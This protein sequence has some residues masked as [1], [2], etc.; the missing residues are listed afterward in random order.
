TW[1]AKGKHAK[2]ADL[3]VK[4]LMFD[5]TR[6]YGAARPA[7]LSLP[8]YPFAKESYWLPATGKPILVQTQTAAAAVLHPLVQRNISDFTQQ[9]FSAVFTGEEFFLKDHIVHGQRILPGVAYLEMAR[10]AILHALDEPGDGALAVRLENVAWLQPLVVGEEPVELYIALTLEDSGVI[11]FTAYTV[12]SEK[13]ERVYARGRAV[14]VSDEVAPALDLAELQ[15]RCTETASGQQCYQA[16]NSVGLTLGPA[17]RSVQQ[18]RM[19]TDAQAA[20]LVVGELRL[21]DSVVGTR[22]AYVLH[23]GLLDSALQ[24]SIGL[25]QLNTSGL[26]KL[27]VPFAL[28]SITIFAPIPDDAVSVV[29]RHADNPANAA[30]QKLD[31]DVTDA[32]GRVCV[33]LHNFTSRVMEGD[34]EVEKAQTVML[35][36]VWQ[37]EAPSARRSTGYARHHIVLCE[38]Q[39]LEDAVATELTQA[40][41]TRLDSRAGSFAERYTD[42]AE[43]LLQYLQEALQATAEGSVLV[44]LVVP[45]AGE[46]AVLRGLG[47]L[48]KSASQENPR[49]IGQV[50][51]I[52]AAAPVREAVLELSVEGGSG[53]QDV[54]YVD[55]RREV[56]GLQAPTSAEVDA[57]L[58]KDGGVYLI[59]GGAGGL[60]LQIAEA[61]VSQSKN[62]VIVVTGRSAAPAKYEQLE[63]LRIGGAVVDYR[64]VDVSDPIAVTNLIESITSEYG[65]LDTVIHCAGVLRDRLVQKKTSLELRDVFA[66]KVMGL[67]N[68]DRATAELPLDR[69]ILFSSIAGVTGNVGQAD[70]AA[71]NAFMDAYAHHRSELA[72]QG[73]RHG[74]TLSVNWPLWAAG[75]MQV[76]ASSKERMRRLTGMVPLETAAGI[77]AL[78]AALRL[79]VSQTAVFFGQ[80]SRIRQRLMGPTEPAQ[81]E[82]T[83][84]EPSLEPVTERSLSAAPATPVIRSEQTTSEASELQEKVLAALLRIASEVLK[85]NRNGIQVDDE[86][87]KYGFDSIMLTGF[88]DALSQKYDLAIS[89]VVFFEYPT[90]QGLAGY[91]VRDHR[92]QM[93]K[94]F[95]GAV[96]PMSA[97]GASSA[98]VQPLPEVID[99]KRSSRFGRPQLVRAGDTR[100]VEREPVAIIGISGSFPQA[101]DLEEFW[102]NLKAG[103]D[104][105]GEIPNSRWDWEQLYG[106]PHKELNKTNIKRAGLIEGADHFDPLFFGISPLEAESMDPQQRVLM[107]YVW[108]AI[109]DA[110]YAPQSLAG[111]NTAILVGTGNSGYSSMLAQNGCAVEGYSAPG[112]VASMGPNRM[113]YLLNLHGPSE[114]IETS[115]SSS[116]VALHRAE[117]L[118]NSGRCEMAIAGGVNLLVASEVQ[119]S[120][121]KAGMLCE[122]GRCKTFS[123]Q[124]NGYVR[125]EGVG[126][127]LLKKLSAAERDGDHIYGLI[128]GSAEN[129]GGRASSLTAPNPK[130]QTGVIKEAFTQA[131]VD[132]R[133]VNYIEAH[134]TGT[135][136]GDPI[137]IQGLKSA[138]AELSEGG[139]ALPISY[140]GVGSVKTNIGH[141]ELA[142][143]AAGV[144]KVLLQMKH[145]TLARSLHSEEI[146]PY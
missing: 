48:L 78:T 41:V 141:L 101:R 1:L 45:A 89:P 118:L 146:N 42:Y 30:V 53:A 137:E 126:M 22:G 11:G 106:D 131:G 105:I 76:E 26:G 125:G 87:S 31:I 71:A 57:A 86:L 140:C 38:V 18:L 90:L 46:S 129:H 116:L 112:A 143:G 15:A 145:Q 8:T 6:L 104:C 123:A 100:S 61:I 81:A 52:E 82:L 23:P 136:L 36:P 117:M 115:C 32:A 37:S 110:G 62:V 13:G 80:A 132:P 64:A 65:S 63:A 47:G 128:R 29:R 70:Y 14:V 67:F 121:S 79:G 9:R 33:R 34:G 39:E 5:W 96:K 103:R 40:N 134:G 72:A 44:Q 108:K 19:G 43:Q 55:G 12:E 68:L 144:I 56:M 69:F 135:P 114:P 127:F 20:T 49:L 73:L 60:G 91:L 4:G 94:H 24:V 83:Q 21:D 35:T 77:Q 142:A 139:E 2:L 66:P 119:V 92:P 133:T 95:G 58:C 3:W 74:Q 138:F 122:D 88:G 98:V 124:A 50:I 59:T 84:V 130:A 25:E 51:A 113:S 16:F 93:L 107:T 10:A 85:I 27:R 120:F 102:E 99:R 111:S 28:D 109:E 17:F 54:R 7:R 75:G 97:A